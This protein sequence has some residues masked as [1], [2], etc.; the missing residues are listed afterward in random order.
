MLSSY[1]SGKSAVS[2][3]GMFQLVSVKKNNN[4][5]SKHLSSSTSKLGTHT[6]T[7]YPH[8]IQDR[9]YNVTWPKRRLRTKRWY[10]LARASEPGESEASYLGFW[11][12]GTCLYSSLYLPSNLATLSSPA[13]HRDLGERQDRHQYVSQHVGKLRPSR[14]RTTT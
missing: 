12:S 3:W 1:T 14:I 8:S 11:L 2:H 10:N 4:S 13:V 7:A 9:Y 6:F 5:N